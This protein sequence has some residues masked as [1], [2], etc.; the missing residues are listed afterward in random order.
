MPQA[1]ARI[2]K[3]VWVLG[4][5]SLL[6]DISSE[7]IHA[8]LPLFMAGTLGA[9]AVW[10]GLVEGIG[11]GAALITK[12]FSGVIADRF[13][14]KKLLVFV[15]YFLG[16]ASKPFFALADAVGVVLGARLFDRI[17]KGM[18]GAPRD[19]IVADVT[20][21]SN[22]AASYGLRQSLDAAGAFI[23]PLLATA[24]L[25]FWT[26]QLQ[27]VF[28]AALVPGVLCL[29]LIVL[30]VEN[31]AAGAQSAKRISLKE[32]SH[33]MT[34]SL[35]E[36]VIVGVLFSLARFSNAF[37]VLRAAGVGI[38][39]AWIPMVVVL[40]NIAFSLSSY[41]LS[42]LAGSMPPKK[43]LELGLVFLA[44][45]DIILAFSCSELALLAGVVVFG[46][47][48]GA[49]QSIFST[50]VAETA[51]SELRATAFGVFNFFSGLALLASGL[52]AGSLWELLGERYTFIGGAVFAAATLLWLRHRLKTQ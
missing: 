34:P 33:V 22:R 44:V 4:F 30:G 24:L 6:M 21:D 25:L 51:R 7:M 43:L 27:A 35:R 41:P 16:V 52:I 32:I 5:V 23:V 17:G 18:R 11:E 3:T 47:H 48:L 40:Q 26:Q 1:K 20:D 2:P 39:Q 9:S 12:V 19:A 37:I 36:L 50:L 45:A 8:L 38:E 31:K 10:I 15:G 13:G 28:W 49:T 46:L 29:L 14:H 42:R